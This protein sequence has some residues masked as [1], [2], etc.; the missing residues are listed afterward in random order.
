MTGRFGTKLPVVG[1]KWLPEG[2]NYAWQA[3]RFVE[4]YLSLAKL[5]G[6][7]RYMDSSKEILDYMLSNRD[8]VR[9]AGKP[10]EAP[11]HY[12]PTTYM[13]HRGTPAQGWRRK[14]GPA[15]GVSV[16]IDGR[17]CEMFIQWC[18]VARQGF[19]EIYEPDI[20]RYLAR[21]HETIEQHQPAFFTVIKVDPVKVTY[22]ATLPAGGF[23]HWWHV[24]EMTLPTSEAPRT[25]SGQ[26]PLNHSCTMARAMLGY[27]RLT[28]TKTYR[29]KVQLVVNFYLNSLDPKITDRAIWEYDPARKDR[30]DTED[31]G[32]ASIDLSLVEAAYRAG[33]YGIDDKLV[34]RLVKT[35]HGFYDDT[36][37]DV[38][39]KIDGP[40]NPSVKPRKDYGDRSSIGFASWLWLAQRDPSIAAKVRATYETFFVNDT[41]GFVMGGWGNLLYAEGL[42]A[43]KV[44]V[45]PAKVGSPAPKAVN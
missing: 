3:A 26:I 28:G 31:V 17:I 19:P 2:D 27:D 41:S 5:T 42:I 10:M 40:V 11:Y 44:K 32:H 18:E 43:G 37:K 9:F 20:T 24:N 12:A 23:R 25:Y 1:E 4:G 13:F 38:Y 22:H 7:R 30:F 8:D 29:D 33:G 35:F 45:A 39:F 21:V 6:E 14:S 36:T 16:L 15:M 34:E